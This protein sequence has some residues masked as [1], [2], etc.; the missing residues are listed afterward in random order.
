[1]AVCMVFGMIPGR[2]FAEDNTAEDNPAVEET[3]TSGRAGPT[4]FWSF[5][6]STGTLAFTG[7][8]YLYSHISV[9]NDPDYP[10]EP[11]PEDIQYQYG[12]I[13]T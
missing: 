4:A 13:G 2:A 9:P 10:F 11:I 6:A 5:D 3:E 7:S 1:M 12:Y 8:G